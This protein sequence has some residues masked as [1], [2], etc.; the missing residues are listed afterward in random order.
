MVLTASQ[1]RA[2]IY[3]LLDHVIETGEP[4]EISRKGVTVRVVAE[5]STH[6]LDNLVDRRHLFPQGV[7]DL[8]E[9]KTPYTWSEELP[10]LDPEPTP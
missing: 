10:M 6:W 8:H 9:F 3:N 1:L 2:D 5:R 7:D 4:I